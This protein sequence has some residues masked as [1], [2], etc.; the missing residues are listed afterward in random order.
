[1]MPSISTWG[2]S[3]HSHPAQ[4][5]TLHISVSSE[6][7]SQDVVSEDVAI[8]SLGLRM[9]LESMAVPSLVEDATQRL[10]LYEE[11]Q[12][13]S[14]TSSKPVSKWSSS[15]LSTGSYLQ[16]REGPREADAVISR[17]E[18]RAQRT[19]SQP[20]KVFTATQTFLA[21]FTDFPSLGPFAT[22]LSIMPYV[23]INHVSWSL[24]PATHASLATK[25]RKEAVGDAVKRASDLADGLMASDVITSR[26]KR[27]IRCVEIKEEQ[28]RSAGYGNLAMMRSAPGGRSDGDRREELVFEPEEIEVRCGIEATFNLVSV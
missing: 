11:T 14:T 3:T 27:E 10:P 16:Y 5:A 12:S 9:M 13:T 24:T 2:E 4:L 22:T 21:S 19:D 15:N 20:Q 25:S 26:E 17:S 18:S 1:M 6:G 7:Q 28:G 23:S 8:A